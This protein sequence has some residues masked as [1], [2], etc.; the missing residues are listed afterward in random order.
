MTMSRASFNELLIEEVAKRPPLWDVSLVEYRKSTNRTTLWEEIKAALEI[1]DPR[2][3]V[4]EV[5]S[6][7]RILKDTY[8]RKLTELKDETRSG[9]GC[10]AKSRRWPYMEPM[11]F[12][13][14]LMEPHQSHS[15]M[16][17]EVHE[18]P[19]V[20]TLESDWQPEGD[21]QPAGDCQPTGDDQRASDDQLGSSRGKATLEGHSTQPLFEDIYNAP[22]CP[23][24]MPGSSGTQV[25]WPQR[26]GIKRKKDTKELES[27][28]TQ[29]ASVKRALGAFKPMTSTAYFLLSLEE[30]MNETPKHM[31]QHLRLERMNVVSSY[32]CGVYPDLITRKTDP[33]TGFFID[34]PED[35]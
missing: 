5:Q 29:L 7:W 16:Y 19:E 21:H 23:S 35:Q 15:N 1:V 6:Q 31:Q 2:V 10:K 9:S 4:D 13:L 33:N 22:E 14:D 8:R 32:S 27:A 25:P 18:M 30:A 26:Q 3:T 12:M 34:V 20:G 28:D 24:E 11:R 17:I